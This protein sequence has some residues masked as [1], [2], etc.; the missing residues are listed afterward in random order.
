MPVVGFNFT[1]IEV[2]RKGGIRG[3]VNIANNVTIKNVESTDLFLGQA[4]QEGLKF[5]FVFTSKYEPNIGNIT[6]E[7][8]VLFLEDAKKVKELLA[9]W[10]KDKK[11]TS[12]ATEE[13]LNTVLQKCNVE[14]LI[15]SKDVNLPSPIPLPKVNVQNSKK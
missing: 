9:S 15:L 1:K 8:D 13:V 6:L 7:G 2:S 10:K 3:K 12:P 5:V 14:A 4:K 11:L